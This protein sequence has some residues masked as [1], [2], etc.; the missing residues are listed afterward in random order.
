MKHAEVS[1]VEIRK[2]ENGFM[3]RVCVDVGDGMEHHEYVYSTLD[4]AIEAAREDLA[5]S[6]KDNEPKKSKKAG[7]ERET[8]NTGDEDENLAYLR[9]CFCFF[10][11]TLTPSDGCIIAAPGR[12][13]R[14]RPCAYPIPGPETPWVRLSS[15]PVLRSPARSCG[16]TTHQA[17]Q[18]A[19]SPRYKHQP[20]C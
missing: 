16:F 14:K 10:A 11:P 8:E 6:E 7:D 12:L 4:K 5:H 20:R 19:S 9:F 17:R 2:A 18:E 15:A 13:R 3:N 1:S